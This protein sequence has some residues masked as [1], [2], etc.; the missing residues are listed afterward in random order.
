LD[1]CCQSR[2]HFFKIHSFIISD[3]LF[4]TFSILKISATKIDKNER[5][6]YEILAK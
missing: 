2:W 6:L 3:L 5:F 1:G 4:L